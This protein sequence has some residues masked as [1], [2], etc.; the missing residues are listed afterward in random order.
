MRSYLQRKISFTNC[1]TLVRTNLVAKKGKKVCL[2]TGYHPQVDNLINIYDTWFPSLVRPLNYAKYANFEIQ[3]QQLIILQWYLNYITY[4]GW[5]EAFQAFESLCSSRIR[6][7]W[8]KSA[9]L[10]QC[11]KFQMQSAI[12]RENL[13]RVFNCFNNGVNLISCT[14]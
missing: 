7:I 5:D 3:L 8:N 11:F 4:L 13:F 10:I 6:F 12:Y 14:F 1:K 9:N 2:R